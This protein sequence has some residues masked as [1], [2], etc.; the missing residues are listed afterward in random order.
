MRIYLAR[1]GE[2]EWSLTGKH[3]GRSDIPLTSR[4]EANACQLAQRL[5]RLSFAQVFTSPLSR[6]RRTCE[7]AGFQAQA[8]VDPELVEWDY[9]EY[10]GRRTAD[11]RLERPDWYLFRDGCPGGETLNAVGE[12]ADRVIGRLRAAPG[13]VLLFSHGHFLRILTARWL[14]LPAADGRLFALGTASLSAVGYEHAT[15]D[16]AILLWNDDR[17]LIRCQ[18]HES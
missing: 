2:T 13:D 8:V 15:D 7:L 5:A 18:S 16:P 9:G 10:E 11:I 12:R 17:H 4:G 6:A 14:G 1:H 3:T